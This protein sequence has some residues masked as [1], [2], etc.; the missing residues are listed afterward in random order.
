MRQQHFEGMVQKSTTDLAMLCAWEWVVV[1]PT[2]FEIPK[3]L[4]T[5]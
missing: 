5:T 3:S 4:R 1:R 2:V